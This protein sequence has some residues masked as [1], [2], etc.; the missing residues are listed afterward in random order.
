MNE[1]A[2]LLI[3][4]LEELCSKLER[5]ERFVS[6]SVV[7]KRALAAATPVAVGLAALSCN[8]ESE[9]D[10]EC[11]GDDCAVLCAD[12][13]DNDGD[14]AVDCKDSDCSLAANCGSGALYAVPLE[15]KCADGVDNDGNGSIDCADPNCLSAAECAGARYGTPLKETTCDDGKDN[16]A[17]ELIDCADPDCATALACRS[18]TDYG[19]PL[20]ESDCGDGLDNDGDGVVDCKDTDCSCQVPIYG[21][22]MVVPP[23]R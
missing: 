6:W 14:S 2:K 22:F 8:G 23:R 10:A 4:Y 3:A 13:K 1:H 21:I 7:R 19:V 12:G 18:V 17:D 20:F 9:D 16:D 11:S 15:T 5:R